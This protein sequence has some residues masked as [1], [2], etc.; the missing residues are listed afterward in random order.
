MKNIF[1]ISLLKRA[2]TIKKSKEQEKKI[3]VCN[4]KIPLQKIESCL[5]SL[6]HKTHYFK[7]I[8][9]KWEKRNYQIKTQ[10]K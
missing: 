6:T 7:A 9:N 10:E 5:N 8:A 2:T 3:Q 4:E 1:N